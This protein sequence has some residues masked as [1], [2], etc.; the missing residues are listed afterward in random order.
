MQHLNKNISLEN[1]DNIPTKF[2]VLQWIR[3][4]FQTVTFQLVMISDYVNTYVK[5]I[6]SDRDMKWDVLA[7]VGNYPVRIGLLKQNEAAEEYPQSY[8][9]L[10]S[11]PEDKEKIEKIDSAT[12]T[13]LSGNVT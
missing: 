7:S 2:D 10:I 6:Y 8:L 12:P 5:V 9:N 4:V 3:I 11:T 1:A 13:A